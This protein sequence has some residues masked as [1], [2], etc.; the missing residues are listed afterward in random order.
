MNTNF[1]FLKKINNSLY[2]I[3]TEAEKLYKD[4]YF[5]QCIV[6]TRRFGEQVCRTILQENGRQTGAF[7]DMLAMLKNKSQ[8]SI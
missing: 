3:I 5:E 1:E 4:E 2:N 7:D 8:G 6:Q